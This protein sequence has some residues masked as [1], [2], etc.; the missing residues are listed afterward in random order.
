MPWRVQELRA[1]V[2]RLTDQLR[3]VERTLQSIQLEILSTTM[4]LV[5]DFANMKGALVYIRKE[6][7]SAR[8]CYVPT[9]R[10]D[11]TISIDHNCEEDDCLLKAISSTKHLFVP[12]S[13]ISTGF[14]SI[15]F[16]VNGKDLFGVMCIWNHLFE[17]EEAA[18]PIISYL[19]EG[20]SIQAQIQTNI[21]HLRWEAGLK[22]DIE[23]Q[24]LLTNSLNMA[25][26]EWQDGKPRFECFMKVLNTMLD[27]TE[28]EYGFFGD[29]QIVDGRAY[30]GAWACTNV[31]WDKFTREWHQEGL[32]FGHKLQ[33]METIYG[34]I[35]KG[36]PMICNQPTG[37]WLRM[38]NGHPEV[39]NFMVIPLWYK[40]DIIGMISL[41][42]SRSGYPE[43]LFSIFKPFIVNYSNILQIERDAQAKLKMITEVSRERENSMKYS[44]VVQHILRHSSHEFKTPLN[45]ICGMIDI[46]SS[47]YTLDDQFNSYIATIRTASDALLLSVNQLLEF[48]KLKVNAFII[49]Q[50]QF[51]FMET[52]EQ[53][54]DILSLYTNQKSLPLILRFDLSVPHILIGDKCQLTT[55]LLTI[56]QNSTKFTDQGHILLETKLLE[57]TDNLV[58]VRLI[59][60]DCAYVQN[61][62][63]I[64]LCFGENANVPDEQIVA[65]LFQE[66]GNLWSLTLAQQITKCMGGTYNLQVFPEGGNRLSMEIT[67]GY[68]KETV[69]YFIP[70]ENLNVLVVNPW[71]LETHI[72][73]NYLS[74]WK[75]NIAIA[76]DFSRA[77]EIMK[78]NPQF[79]VC[80]VDADVYFQNLEPAV[81][82][83][84]SYLGNVHIIATKTFISPE[85]W[86]IFSDL[87]VMGLKKPIKPTQLYAA[88]RNGPNLGTPKAIEEKKP[89]VQQS[90]RVLVV[91]DNPVNQTML[92]RM[93]SKMGISSSIAG[94]GQKAVEAAQETDYDIIL[95][96]IQMPVMDGIQATRT[97]R[98]L[99]MNLP[100]VA[101]SASN[102]D[103]EMPRCIDAG[104]NDFLWKPVKADNLNKML[105]KYCNPLLGDVGK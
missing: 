93:L 64:N 20:L 101:V 81:R 65:R 75:C 96:D 5:S 40:T 97:I 71:E 45:A 28:S 35:L 73:H 42:N 30:C 11:E 21:L 66:H 2:D 18:Y 36:E 83:I 67:F 49:E 85:D 37:A 57:M 72:I 58:K 22:S 46:I 31:S 95:M 43:K 63:N 88:I 14:M 89:A 29:L 41:A 12:C 86:K 53:V 68:I 90:L 39:K 3:N 76:E 8:C 24:Y 34:P 105:K 82:V 84:N 23:K 50:Q 13:P 17:S 70:F 19:S 59:I 6:E 47:S 55:L 69:P 104:M 4:R 26:R 91:D 10:K 27:L 61:Q 98:Q 44:E 94:D 92:V 74:C 102:P 79:H 60:E 33:K 54:A 38:P 32:T 78:N 16:F 87:K 48:S 15:P 1:C 77:S 99:G 80:V 103:Q 51:N 62:N 25:Q 9:W 100:V 56:G 52:M 7:N